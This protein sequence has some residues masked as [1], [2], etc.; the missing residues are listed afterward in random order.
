[1]FHISEQWHVGYRIMGVIYKG[2]A[3]CFGGLKALWPYHHVCAEGLRLERCA[4]ECAWSFET[5]IKA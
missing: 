4:S 2:V 5:A 1:M 3:F